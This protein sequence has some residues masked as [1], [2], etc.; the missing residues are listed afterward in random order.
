MTQATHN[1]NGALHRKPPAYTQDGALFLP[2]SLGPNDPTPD[3]VLAWVRALSPQHDGRLYIRISEVRSVFG[4]AELFYHIVAA[5]FRE[6]MVEVERWRMERLGPR[7][8]KPD[9]WKNAPSP[10][11]QIELIY[12][13]KPIDL[14]RP[15]A[16]ECYAKQRT[17]QKPLTKEEREELWT[18]F[19]GACA[20]CGVAV[21]VEQMAID[22]DIPRSR[23]GSNDRENLVC[24]CH[25]CNQSKHARTGTEYLRLVA[26]RDG[27]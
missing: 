7:K 11:D 5:M 10:W 12:A 24:S 18:A 8:A 13:I 19:D 17:K 20:Y 23:G 15:I 6:G 2:V 4:A 16:F 22:H 14:A 26:E 9:P 25:Y 21:T 27:A 1:V 3:D